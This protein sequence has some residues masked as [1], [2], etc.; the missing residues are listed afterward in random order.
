MSRSCR[1][2]YFPILARCCCMAQSRQASAEDIVFDDVDFAYTNPNREF[3]AAR[4]RWRRPASRVANTSTRARPGDENLSLLLWES[5][6]PIAKIDAKLRGPGRLDAAGA[7]RGGDQRRQQDEGLR[8]DRRTSPSYDFNDWD[9][10]SIS[11]N[12]S[13]DWYFSG[14]IASWTRPADQRGADGQSQWRLQIHRRSVDGGRRHIHLQHERLSR[15]SRGPFPMCLA[16]ATGSSSRR[17]LRGSMPL[18]STGRGASR[19]AGRPVWSSMDKA[20]IT[21][22]CERRRWSSSIS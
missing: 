3:R 10:R 7:F 13:L 22:I 15:H 5:T 6:A 9:H 17:S 8:L 19:P 18:S 1:N 12:T 4:Q 21:T 11:P 16:S 2:L 14:D 20:P